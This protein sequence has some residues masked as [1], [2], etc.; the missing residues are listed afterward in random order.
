M[1][2][3]YK[4]EYDENIKDLL[5]ELQAYIV[6]IDKEKYNIITPDFRESYFK[7]TME[8]VNKNNGKIYLVQDDNRIV[9]LV[10]GIINNEATEEPGF[11]APKRGRVTEL[12]VSKEYRSKGYGKILLNKI[13]KYLKE[14][15]CQDILI[16]VF[17]Y[18]ELG[19]NFYGMNGYHLRMT[20]VT[21]TNI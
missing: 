17:G 15:G 20:E 10:I 18:N 14:Q 21:K 11:K 9:G 8:E 7:D 13:E 1:I 12:I 16:S 19:L 4:P 2:I 5:E 3:D 6:S